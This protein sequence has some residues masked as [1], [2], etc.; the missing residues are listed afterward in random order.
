[1]V[2]A[3]MSLCCRAD[4]DCVSRHVCVRGFDHQADYLGP[5]PVRIADDIK[6]PK[7]GRKL[8]AV[9]RLDQQSACNFNLGYIIERLFR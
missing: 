2:P 5:R 7:E 3:L 8:P 9:T 1:M 4:P 6:A